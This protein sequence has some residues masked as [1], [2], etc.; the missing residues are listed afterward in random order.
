MTN[1]IIIA[2]ASFDSIIDCNLRALLHALP[3]DDIILDD[4][5]DF[6]LAYAITDMID[7]NDDQLDAT[8]DFLINSLNTM[9]A[10][11]DF[12]APT[13]AARIRAHIDTL[14][15]DLD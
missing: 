12:D 11:I 3:L 10:Y 8:C 15:D 13:F 7:D 9:I 1:S 5:N 2:S 6:D 14:S 4:S